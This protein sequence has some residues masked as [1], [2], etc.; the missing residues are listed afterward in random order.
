VPA[1]GSVPDYCVFW[2]VVLIRLTGNQALRNSECFDKLV[3]R[4]AVQQWAESVVRG[5]AESEGVAAQSF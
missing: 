5:V 2:A 1:D 4:S 3:E